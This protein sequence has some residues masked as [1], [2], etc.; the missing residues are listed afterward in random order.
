MCQG[1]GLR[2]HVMFVGRF[3]MLLATFS[4][5]IGPIAGL[6]KSSVGLKSLRS[7][8]WS[9]MKRLLKYL[10]ETHRSLMFVGQP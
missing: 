1:S 7:P 9:R 6:A 8:S 3:F 2:V 10:P 5:K 4:T